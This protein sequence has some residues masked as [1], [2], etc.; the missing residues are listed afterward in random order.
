LGVGLPKIGAS[1]LMWLDYFAKAKVVGVDIR[2]ECK[3]IE[4]ER[5]SI[6]I[7]DL[8]KRPFVHELASTYKPTVIVDDASHSWGA[9]I[10]VF[11]VLFWS[12]E[13]GGTYILE[14]TINS[15]GDRREKQAERWYQDTATYFIALALLVNGASERHP[16]L[17]SLR[18]SG[19]L[20][21]I[22]AEVD[23]VEFH[24]NGLVI[25][26]QAT[27]DTRRLHRI[28]EDRELANVLATNAAERMRL[29]AEKLAR[30]A[31][32]GR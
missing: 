29:R 14:D 10:G 12:L 30:R 4:R 25:V 21:A 26:K 24:R 3:Q 7:G 15:F 11:E 27:T 2:P 23:F 17:D 5:L 19:T 1:L 28:A 32:R 20:L 22:A 8:N 9:Q 18:P 13:P 6:V 16:L 31:A